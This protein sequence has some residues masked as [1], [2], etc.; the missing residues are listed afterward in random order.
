MITQLH[1]LL[2]KLCSAHSLT[3]VPACQAA[4][5]CM[6]AAWSHDDASCMF[7]IAGRLCVLVR[8]MHYW[9]IIIIIIMLPIKP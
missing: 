2:S 1:G 3:A 4:A 8:L 6:I 5:A 9:F 7:T